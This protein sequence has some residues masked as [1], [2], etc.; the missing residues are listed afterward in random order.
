M[1]ASGIGKSIS[2]AR[3]VS[4]FAARPR[5]AAH[6]LPRLAVPRKGLASPNDEGSVCGPSLDYRAAEILCGVRED[7]QELVGRIE[8]SNHHAVQAC[9]LSVLPELIVGV[10]PSIEMQRAPVQINVLIGT[11]EKPPVY[12]RADAAI[13]HE[14]SI[15]AGVASIPSR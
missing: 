6:R 15:D 7:M 12:Y 14:L 11:V 8:N 4:P 2:R 3:K 10:R 13:V 9:L 1:T 5:S